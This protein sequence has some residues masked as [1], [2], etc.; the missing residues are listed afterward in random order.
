MPLDKNHFALVIGKENDLKIV[1]R[2]DGLKVVESLENES[3][4]E[5]RAQF[6][7]LFSCCHEGTYYANDG[8]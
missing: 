2:K 7:S 5:I 6:T 3:A 1:I 4:F 8:F